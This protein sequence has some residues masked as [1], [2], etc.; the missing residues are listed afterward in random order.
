[1]RGLSRYESAPVEAI[2][3]AC[4]RAFK[5]LVDLAI[6]ITEL[7][8]QAKVETV[9]E[10]VKAGEK[11]KNKREL[12]K[13][14]EALEQELNRNGDG[15]SIEELE[16]ELKN[17]EIDVIEGEIDK[18]TIELKELQSERDHLRDQRQTIQNEIR[19]KD[20]NALAANASEEAEAHLTSISQNA[21]HYLRFQIAAL[22][23][24]QQIEDY[25]KENQAPVLG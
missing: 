17:S 18:I 12:Q 16:E 13:N 14:S 2:R 15:L 8:K 6:V 5:N 21:E 22:I 9:E 25:R 7:K 24:E 3:G 19:Q 20:G 23:L 4:R 10:L 11:S 1:M